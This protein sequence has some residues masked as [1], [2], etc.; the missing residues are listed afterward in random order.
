MHP[1]QEQAVRAKTIEN[2]REQAL[3]ERETLAQS[4]VSDGSAEKADLF[5]KTFPLPPVCCCPVS[6]QSSDGSR[7]SP[8][9]DTPTQLP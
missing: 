8:S 2:D 6:P 9:A 1:P 7:V 4:I 3:V 5:T